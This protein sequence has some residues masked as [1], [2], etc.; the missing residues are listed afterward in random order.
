MMSVWERIVF[1]LPRKLPWNWANLLMKTTLSWETFA[2][3]RGRSQLGRTGAVVVSH[4]GMPT[5]KIVHPSSTTRGFDKALL[6]MDVDI[7]MTALKVAQDEQLRATTTIIPA[8]RK[9]P[10]VAP[11]KFHNKKERNIP[12]PEEIGLLFGIVDLK[13]TGRGDNLGQSARSLRSAMSGGGGNYKVE[14]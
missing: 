14:E 5:L 4:G 12:D 1:S 3:T 8:D 7:L 10:S 6:A 9:E 2:T 13:Q 11:Y